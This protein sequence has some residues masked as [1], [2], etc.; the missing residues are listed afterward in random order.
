MIIEE[1]Y[2]DG[3]QPSAGYTD[4]RRIFIS[5]SLSDHQAGVMRKHA[6]CHIWLLHNLRRPDNADN[7]LWSVATD[8][9]IALNIYTEDDEFIIT[10]P[11][12]LLKD[13]ITRYSLPQDLPEN[14]IYAEDIYHWLA[15]QPVAKQLNFPKSHDEDL[16]DYG[17]EDDEQK[18]ATDDI[19]D[20]I[21]KAREHCQELEKVV[22]D[23]AR[24]VASR[25][26]L[27]EFQ[28]RVEEQRKFTLHGAL[29]A[30]LVACYAV[31]RKASYRRPKRRENPDFI[32]KGVVKT[33][34]RP[35]IIVY[36]D[37]SASF[38]ESKTRVATQRIE[39]ICKKYRANVRVDVLYFNDNILDDD[40]LQGE[41]GTNYK[42]VRD[43]ISQHD[44][45]IAVVITD[46]DPCEYL[47]PVKT[48][49][50]VVPIGSVRTFFARRIGGKDVI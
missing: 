49:V 41:G 2:F 24:S 21:S 5:R 47:M 15:S 43:S 25:Q 32:Q 40:P 11:R 10:R 13:V 37:R 17:Y 39:D 16:G 34:N 26:N 8:A 29:E 18:N 28:K 12:S 4:F 45:E 19:Q 50:L 7:K 27:E 20:L 35:H 9:E 30:E 42:A 14:L 22:A 44:P 33:R 48:R 46:D 31:C 36:C 6:S 38:D 1:K 3:L 23:K